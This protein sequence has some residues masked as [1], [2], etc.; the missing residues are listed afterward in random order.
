MLLDDKNWY[1]FNDFK[2]KPA[3]ASK[4]YQVR[5]F[6][7][8]KEYECFLLASSDEM[9]KLRYE[10]EVGGFSV[11]NTFEKPYPVYCASM[12]SSDIQHILDKYKIQGIWVYRPTV[13][14]TYE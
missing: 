13:K 10:K 1:F 11:L 4:N 9:N 2:D 3:T 14:L 12:T 8:R 5:T 7:N 6:C